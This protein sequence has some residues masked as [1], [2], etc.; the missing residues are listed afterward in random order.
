AAG[1]KAS[2]LFMLKMV[3]HPLDEQRKIVSFLDAKCA[4]IDADIARRRKLIERLSAYRRSLIYEV[5]TGKREV[6]GD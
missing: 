6:A 2:K 3:L 1:I 5:V 4:A